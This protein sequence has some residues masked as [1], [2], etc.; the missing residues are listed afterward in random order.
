MH[1]GRGDLRG[2]ERRPCRGRPEHRAGGAVRRRGQPGR[3]KHLR[4]VPQ[5]SA[6]DWQPVASGF[7]RGRRR[8]ARRCRRGDGAEAAGRHDAPAQCAPRGQRRP[9]DLG[10]DPGTPPR[11]G[12]QT[13]S[14]SGKPTV[15][16]SEPRGIRRGHPRPAGTGCGRG[17][18]ASARSGGPQFRQYRRGPDALRHPARG[19]SERG[20]LHQPPRGRRARHQGGGPHL[21]QLGVPLA[22]PLGPG[23]GRPLR[24]PRRAGGG[25]CLPGRRRVHLRADLHLGS[26]HS[27]RGH[28]CL[29]RR[30]ARGADALRHEPAGRRRRPGR[31]GHRNPAGLRP[32]RDPPGGRRLPAP[33]GR[34][35]RRP[36]PPSRLVLCRGR[37]GRCGDH[38]PAPHPRRDHHRSLQRDRTVG[39]AESAAH[40][41]LPSHGVRRGPPL[42][43]PDSRP[44]R[45]RGL[46][47]AAERRRA[48]GPA[49]LLRRG[50]RGR[51]FRG[52]GP[53]RAGSPAGEPPLR[54]AARTR[55]GE[56]VGTRLPAG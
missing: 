15:P 52:R 2:G 23:H 47:A 31:C 27:H 32:G 39:H 46:A 53:D 33:A 49:P 5:R 48:R 40:L 35:L 50:D 30:G 41:H 20:E 25:P 12:G 22:A 56:R 14:R 8:P 34:P 37:I 45:P 36:D 24:H 9:P 17:E 44:S 3:P 38:H 26:Q 11:R 10:G 54:A 13:G 55:A 1:R 51:R 16:A 18:L 7:R 6:S 4:H 29:D 42:R 43:R 28:R 19:V 21:L